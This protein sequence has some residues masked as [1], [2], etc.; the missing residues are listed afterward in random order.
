MRRQ[1]YVH[2]TTPSRSFHTMRGREK[3][4]ILTSHLL[5]LLTDVRPSL[6]P[7]A[8]D[9]FAD[10]N[11]NPAGHSASSQRPQLEG[12]NVPLLRKHAPNLVPSSKGQQTVLIMPI[13]LNTKSLCRLVMYPFFLSLRFHFSYFVLCSSFITPRYLI[14]ATCSL[15]INVGTDSHRL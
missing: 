5:L 2:Y 4:K 7:E 12:P 8:S 1:L 3:K 10:E 11:E 13:S 14:A 15:D 9:S 6:R